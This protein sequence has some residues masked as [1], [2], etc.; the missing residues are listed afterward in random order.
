MV[1]NWRIW[2]LSQTGQVFRAYY[3]KQDCLNTGPRT[4]I[5][6]LIHVLNT[7]PMTCIMPCLEFHWEKILTGLATHVHRVEHS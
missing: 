3:E 5:M 4:C 6:G 1:C 7:G 2:A